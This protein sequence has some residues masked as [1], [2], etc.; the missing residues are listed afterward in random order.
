MT[1]VNNTETVAVGICKHDKV[2]VLWVSIPLHTFG[3]QRNQAHYLLG[4]LSSIGTMEV[5]AKAR[6]IIGRAVAALKCEFRA[7]HI[8]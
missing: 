6:V 8:A 1:Q 3:A 7:Y 2:R 5:E 4:L